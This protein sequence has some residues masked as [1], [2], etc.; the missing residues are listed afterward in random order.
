MAQDV[1]IKISHEEDLI[2]VSLPF[3]CFFLYVLYKSL[4][5]SYSSVFCVDQFEVLLVE[6][7]PASYL[8]YRDRPVEG[9]YA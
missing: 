7:Y 9:G 2:P 5:G 4:F 3:V 6:R 8:F 1:V